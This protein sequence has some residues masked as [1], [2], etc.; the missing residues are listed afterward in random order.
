M[1]IKKRLKGNIMKQITR[2]EA[3]ALFHTSQVISTDIEQNKNEMQILLTLS[4]N[5]A[6]LVKW[7]LHDHAKSYFLADLK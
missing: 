5:R 7:N 3:E 1:G 2:D 4:N 6:F